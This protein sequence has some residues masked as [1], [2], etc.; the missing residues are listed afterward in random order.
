MNEIVFYSL[1]KAIRTYRQYAH[2]QLSA[3]GFD[4]TIDQWLILKSI[5]K[6]P[7]LP[8][9][10]IAEI[11]FKDYASLTRIIELLVKKGYLQRAMHMHDR[12]RFTLTLAD[13][14]HNVL[15]AM[16]TVIVSN[17]KQ[18]LSGIGKSDIDNLQKTLNR[19]IQNCNES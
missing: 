13:K 2:Q 11:T 4:V 3:H 12:R 15:K 14:A 6:N 10:Q 1:D 9:Q 5:N 7:D 16:Q 18:A 8:Q 19:I 17:R